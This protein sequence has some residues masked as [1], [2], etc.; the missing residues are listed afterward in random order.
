MLNTPRLAYKR[1]KLNEGG[2]GE[3]VQKESACGQTITNKDTRAIECMEIHVF[4]CFC[5]PFMPSFH[6]QSPVVYLEEKKRPGLSTNPNQDTPHEVK[7]HLYKMFLFQN[8][9]NITNL[10]N[11]TQ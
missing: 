2:G 1:N 5:Y 11:Y 4:R 7:L 6:R 10:Q 8:C 9:G 3:G